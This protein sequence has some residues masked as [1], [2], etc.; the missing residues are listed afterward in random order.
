M[1]KAE[2]TYRK[3]VLVCTNERSEERSCCMSRGAGDLRHE[4]KMRVAAIDPNIRVSKTG[5]L[6]KC[7]DGAN[8][9]IMPDNVW[10]K[11]VT[12]DDIQEVVNL[13]VA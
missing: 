13:I 6:G 12:M 3:L 10:L 4:L 2:Q 7:S 11:H 8:V 9:V 1:E 5:C